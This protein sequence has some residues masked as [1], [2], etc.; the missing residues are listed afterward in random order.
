ALARGDRARSIQLAAAADKLRSTLGVPRVPKDQ[1]D[2]E[3]E[4]TA[5]SAEI[6]QA[7]YA[8]HWEEGAALNQ[9]QAIALALALAD[10][11]R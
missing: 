1:R 9:E 6:G 3:A 7:I 11:S 2:F 5:Y 8:R 4:R 10:P